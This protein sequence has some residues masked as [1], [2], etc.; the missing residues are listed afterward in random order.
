MAM[1]FQTGSTVTR[2]A[3]HVTVAAM[4]CQT[5]RYATV[6]ATAYRVRPG[7][8][9]TVHAIAAI[10]TTTVCRI[11]RIAIR[12]TAVDNKWRSGAHFK[13][14]LLLVLT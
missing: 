10:E 3:C 11:D 7:G 12:M 13:N 6:M 8:M 9:A 14:G 5:A 1:A 4:A 2:I